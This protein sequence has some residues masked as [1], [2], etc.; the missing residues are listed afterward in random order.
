MR[1][2]IA[3]A[4]VSLDGV[5]QAP[6]GPEEDPSGGFSHGGWTFP[7]FDE[8]GG[9]A[10]VELF[11]T[12]FDLLLGRKTYEIFN[13]YWPYHGDNPIGAAFNATT[14]HVATRSN[15]RTFDWHNTDVLLGDA[16][17]KV[18]ALKETPGPTLLTQGS[19]DL[20][21]TLQKAGLVDEWRMMTFPV[22]LG[23][24]KRL[25]EEG[26]TAGGLKLEKTSV[27]PSGVITATYSPAGAIPAGS[28][29]DGPPSEAE[30]KRRSEW[31]K[32]G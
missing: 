7:Y 14:K 2:L 26:V 12:P 27:T 31:A 3:A 21:Q 13:A 8:E 25:F 10:M 24:G 17:T 11:S 29:V 4:F 23:G 22:L 6:G 18:A 15:A 28:H 1:K 5:M 32:E 9:Q 19:G 30:L 20:L 16:A